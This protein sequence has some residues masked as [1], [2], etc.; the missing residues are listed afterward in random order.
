MTKLSPPPS[1]PTPLRT[2]P[3]V[4][5]IVIEF[6]YVNS[7][8]FLVSEQTILLNLK[9]QWGNPPSLTNWNASSSPCNWPEI[10]CNTNAS[11]IVLKLE[12]KGLTGALPPPICDLQNLEN[13]LLT[14]NYLTGEFPRVLYNCS[15][16][17]QLD[18]SQN[19]F[20]GT[21][22]D[23]IDRLSRLKY[24]DL[25]ANNFTG[26]IPPAIGNLSELM[27]L[28]LYQ[29]LF[30][31]SIPS[32]IGN[33]SNLLILGL[34][35]NNFAT[36]EIPPEFGRLGNLTKLWMPQTNLIG[37]IPES[38]GN[39][40]NLELLDLSSNNLEGEIPSGLFLLKNLRNLYMY[41]NNLSGEIPS[42]VES[43]NL[44]E[45]DISMN[46]ITGS[47]PE[48][49]GKLQQL[50][51][52]NLF[53][54][55]L[56]GYIPAS[57]SQIPTLKIFRLFRNNLSGELP[58]EIGLHSNLEAI[59][60]S[61]NKLTGKLPENLCAGGALLVV[62]AFSNNL[63]GEIPRSLQR[64]HKLHTIQLY[65]NSFTGEF[66]SG[67]WSLSDLS[68]LRISGNFLSGEL[69][70]SIA[71][72]L[73][74]LEIDDNKFSG[75]IP[76]G[77]S[78]WKKLNVFIAS[79]NFLSGEIPTGFTNLSQLSVLYLDGNSL[80]GELPATVSSWTSLTTLN[81]ARNN[82][83]GEIPPA[84][85]SLPHLLD[86]DLSENQFSGKI[87]P[88]MSSLRLT[89]L[90]LSSNKLTGRIPNAF[91]NLA[92][93]N[94][95]LNNPD[96]CASSP[97]PNL[98]NCNAAVGYT[99]SS[100]SQKVSPKIIAI[101]VVI[102]AF[103]IVFAIL[104]TIIMFRG[105]L[106]K[107]QKLDLTTWKLTSFHTLRFTEANILCC[108]TDN[109][110]IGSGGSGKVYQIEV[111]RHGEY[112]AVKRIWNTR[113]VDQVLEKEFLSEVQILGSI[114]HSNIV[115]LLCCF[116]SEDSKLLV[117]EYMENQSLDK[118]LHGNKKMKTHRGLV[119]YVVLDWPRRLQIAIGVAQGLCYMHHDCSPP[120][121]HRDVKSSN[122][123]LDSEFKA[124]IADFGLAKIL[125][126][127]KPGQANTLSAIA[128]SFGYI[129]PEYA[130]S[131]TITER[132]DVYSFG[133]VLLELVTGKEPHEGD[134]DMNLAEWT[135][136]HFSEG[137]STMEEA[138]D[139]EIKQANCYMEEISLVFKLGLIC[140]ST[141]PSSRPSMK[142][143]L[144]ILRR[145]DNPSS[146]E[147]KVG[148]EIDV[149][150]LL[151]R[152]SYLSNYRRGGNKVVN[153][154]IDILDGRL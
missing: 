40:Y 127:P 87:P 3:F 82:L 143:V 89:S 122:I 39:L 96:L 139:P 101:I 63:T 114:R 135:W 102:S 60:V 58:P 138:L 153:E 147:R 117:Y 107:K 49:F 46:K 83:S 95:F 110:L 62:V 112:V 59:E 28:Q 104:C 141:L 145:C 10:T 121:I 17:I 97:I 106:K 72:N 103:V 69:P 55:R 54:N 132:A 92:Y 51:V 48:D 91:D 134:G 43:V 9:Q 68:S 137:K 154:G 25:G 109:N 93:E 76:E 70:S 15:K 123:L 30:D 148:E 50:E 116:S 4:L 81:L 27:Y 67:I 105:Y 94:S 146:E 133:V 66:P 31:G 53:S 115:K 57:I 56:S 111:G 23:D 84:I 64:C 149:T 33:L 85:T 38:L 119:H 21:L 65:D 18:I 99:K 71:W 47:I 52:L 136:K 140:T 75:R 90:N 88:Q 80:S 100:H 128:G 20:V 37:K 7:Q 86:L 151:R 118:W 78:S 16:L 24:A 108:L 6:L 125:T 129:P 77:I 144:E 113:K 142:E 42:A 131:T 126:K 79:N 73:S 130:Y 98:H 11:V 74:R 152:E 36:P 22:P 8:K 32:E 1:L 124:R 13:M 5:I 35:Y 12:S 45:I 44:T 150:P 19:A 61:E 120:I 41:K 14:D 2:I 26:D 29:N 34:A